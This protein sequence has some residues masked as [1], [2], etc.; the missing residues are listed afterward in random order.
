[1]SP[2]GAPE[3]RIGGAATRGAP[4]DFEVD[5]VALT[6]YRGESILAALL[7]SGRRSLRETPRLGT[8]RGAYCGIGLC[9]DCVM[10]VD[11]RANVRTCRTSVQE[12]MVVETQKGDGPW[13]VE[14]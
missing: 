8:A 4:L 1:M 9:F 11:G 6:A 10:V 13:S 3:R 5:G 14:P 12:G 2:A 7:A